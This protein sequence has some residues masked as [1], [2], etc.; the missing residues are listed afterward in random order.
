MPS[1]VIEQHCQLMTGSSLAAAFGRGRYRG[2][3]TVTDDE[4]IFVSDTGEEVVRD[5]LADI[6]EV[7][8][9]RLG[10]ITVKGSR[11]VRLFLDASD[12]GDR[13]ETVVGEVGNAVLFAK[14]LG[15]FSDSFSKRWSASRSRADRA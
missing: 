1:A 10:G 4:F 13:P 5:R 14:V 2:L 7:S 3:A 8:F 6:A 12:F 15:D 9:S 11:K